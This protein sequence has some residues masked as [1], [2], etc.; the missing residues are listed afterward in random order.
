M[1]LM[2]DFKLKKSLRNSFISLAVIFALIF[3]FT[4]SIQ[5]EEVEV[6]EE[7]EEYLRSV[8]AENHIYSVIAALESYEGEDLTVDTIKSLIDE[9]VNENI[10]TEGFYTAIDNIVRAQNAGVSAEELDEFDESLVSEENH[11]QA[12]SQFA[13]DLAEFA[14]DE[15]NDGEAVSEMAQQ[16]ATFASDNENIGSEGVSEFVEEK[17]AE[18]EERKETAEEKADESE[19]PEDISENANDA[20]EEASENADQA[21]QGTETAE[22]AKDNAGND[23]AG[24]NQDKS[25]DNPGESNP[26]N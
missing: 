12:V 8:G 18:A 24:N 4:I 17:K 11:G 14:S 23:N 9:L 2:L 10:D 21:E 5:A 6:T 25:D 19:K 13:H 22:E 1:I 3:T 20:S 26:N 16:L 15:E 7:I